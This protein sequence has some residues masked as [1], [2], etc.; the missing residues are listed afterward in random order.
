MLAHDFLL[1]FS[2]VFDFSLYF[3]WGTKNSCQFNLLL[4][5]IYHIHLCLVLIYTF[6]E[7]SI[8]FIQSVDCIYIQTKNT[9]IIL[10]WKLFYFY[11]KFYIIFRNLQQL[12][13]YK[14]KTITSSCCTL[15]RKNVLNP[16]CWCWN[17]L[18]DEKP[19]QIHFRKQKQ[20]LSSIMLEQIDMKVHPNENS[21]SGQVTLPHYSRSFSFYK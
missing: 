16:F 3:W 14:M 17:K 6:Q 19:K 7:N 5:W 15:Q 12:F 13:F 1:L 11:T 18:V 4:H 9:F 2:H 21:F 8:V 20:K 10:I